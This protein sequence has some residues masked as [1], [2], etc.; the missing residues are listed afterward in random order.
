MTNLEFIR[1]F[2]GAEGTTT[3]DCPDVFS[4]KYSYY[5]VYLNANTDINHG[6]NWINW[7]FMKTDYTLDTSTTYDAMTF[8]PRTDAG[9]SEYRNV[10]QSSFERLMI[11]DNKG[12]AGIFHV[13]TPFES[14]VYS[15]LTTECSSADIVSPLRNFGAFAMG[16]HEETQ[17]NIGFRIFNEQGNNT[18]FNVSVYG[19]RE[20]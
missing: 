13:Y 20:T 18:N 19:V 9:F 2:Q 4:S 6:G 3:I 14:G 10:S 16:V 17:S 11:T 12:M 5:Q 15:Y 7:R 1:N 8:H